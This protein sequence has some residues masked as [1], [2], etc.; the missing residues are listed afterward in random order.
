MFIPFLE[1]FFY[2]MRLLANISRFNYLSS[3]FV[4]YIIHLRSKS[5]AE[6]NTVLI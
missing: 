5:D 1:Y 3:L 4:N 6:A 2:A